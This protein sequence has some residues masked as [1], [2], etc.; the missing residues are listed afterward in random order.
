VAI[1]RAP[2]RFERRIVVAPAHP[3]DLAVPQPGDRLERVL[4]AMLH[5][6]PRVA[7]QLLHLSRGVRRRRAPLGIL[8]DLGRQLAA[9][10]HARV[11]LDQLVDERIAEHRVHE[12]VHV[13]DRARSELASLAQR[14]NHVAHVPGLHLGQQQRPDVREHVVPQTSAVDHDRAH[15]ARFALVEPPEQLAERDFG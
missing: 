6:D 7:D 12:P 15:A 9:V 14:A 3:G 8:V 10:E 13:E 5:G 2:E 11:A 1:T 4:H